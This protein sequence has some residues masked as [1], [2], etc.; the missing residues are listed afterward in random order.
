[1]TEPERE[2]DIDLSVEA[3][4][5]R[6]LLQR[7]EAPR[8]DG[9]FRARLKETFVAGS[10]TEERG[11]PAPSEAEP[12][13][14]PRQGGIGPIADDA[15]RRG[16]IGPIADDEPDR[17]PH[18]SRAPRLAP[19]PRPAT[20]PRRT[21]RFPKPTRPRF[22]AVLAAAAAI[23][24][25]VGIVGNRGPQWRVLQVVGTGFV[26]ADGEPIPVERAELLAQRIHPGV[27]LVLP[28][29]AS[30][31]IAAGSDL[32][33]EILP[34]T[35]LTIPPAPP[36]WFFRKSEFFA[37]GGELRL[38]TGPTFQGA[39]LE[40]H[41]ADAM[42]QVKGTT[43]AVI[44]EPTGTCVCVLEGEV[45]VG[46]RGVSAGPEG[47]GGD[48]MMPVTS[49]Q[50]GYVFRDGRT[51]ERAEIR[52]TELVALAKFRALQYELLEQLTH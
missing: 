6:D 30:L 33:M 28:E 26:Q 13:G 15:P 4:R 7:L 18:R 32:A 43:L 36:R 16:G 9:G 37:R 41:T 12:K 45:M 21:F 51:P 19:P 27:E 23:A 24:V 49:G 50:R 52:P 47:S 35:R 42:I 39:K 11:A 20:P 25:A 38:T 8:P 14:A 22:T 2:P 46:A 29:T 34:G 1:M 40:V 3:K 48:A 31:A 5:A 17:T 44:M 10:F